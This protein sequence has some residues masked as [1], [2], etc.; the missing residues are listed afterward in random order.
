M[1][2]QWQ[3]AGFSRRFQAKQNGK[4]GGKGTNNGGPGKGAG[5]G[6]NDKQPM[7]PNIVFNKELN[8]SIE[9]ISPAG[10]NAAKFHHQYKAPPAENDKAAV[11]EYM[12][13]HC[14]TVNHL[15]IVI[16]GKV[17][18]EQDYEEDAEHV[19]VLK[20]MITSAKPG[21]V[22]ISTVEK[23]LARAFEEL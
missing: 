1:D 21:H 20:R 6:K 23:L 4:A 2:S 22:Q 3:Q 18:L 8:D 15:K 13:K 10:P 7:Q 12:K 16:A 5:K 11:Q 19:A 17:R 14:A 9:G